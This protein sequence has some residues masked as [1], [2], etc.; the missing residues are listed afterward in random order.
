MH[1]LADNII[2]IIILCIARNYI[3]NQRNHRTFIL[4]IKVSYHNNT[5]I[6]EKQRLPISY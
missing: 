2:E 5:R 6:K 1:M 3:G 4:E